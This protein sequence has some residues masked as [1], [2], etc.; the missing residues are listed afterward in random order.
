MGVN[1]R[2]FF[3]PIL[4]FPARGEGTLTSHSQPL[5]GEGSG[6]LDTSGNPP[7]SLDNVGER[8]GAVG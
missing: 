2:H 4:T 8:N 1:A 3:P 5:D 6:R 7:P